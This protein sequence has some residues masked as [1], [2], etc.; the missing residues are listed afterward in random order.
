MSSVSPGPALCLS[1]GDQ[2]GEGGLVGGLQGLQE[3][4]ES[5]KPRT[6]IL[7]ASTNQQGR[8]MACPLLLWLSPCP[9][10]V[11]GPHFTEKENGGPESS[12]YFTEGRGRQSSSKGSSLPLPP[13]LGRG[14]AFL[15]PHDPPL[16]DL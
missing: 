11:E 16:M 6:V 7:I 3:N 4:G 1:S 14:W 5:R 9:R 8:G 12:L 10:T 15:P 2:G 13:W